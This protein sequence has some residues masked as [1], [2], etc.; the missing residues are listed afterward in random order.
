MSIKIK[1]SW[2]PVH[3]ILY[4]LYHGRQQ[5]N[6]IDHIDGNKLNN[7]YDNLRDVTQLENTRNTHKK[8]KDTNCIGI[9]CVNRPNL[10][11][12]Y[13]TKINGKQYWLRT[14]DDAIL[15]RKENNLPV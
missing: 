12:K 13:V 5:I 4:F 8:N 3:Q 9:C 1:G 7:K 2:Y 15:L 10:L 14:L 11:A 6:V